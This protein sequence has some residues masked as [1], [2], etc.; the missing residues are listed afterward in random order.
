MESGTGFE[1]KVVGFTCNW[2]T[3]AG[4]DLAGTSRTKYPPNIRIVRVMCSGRIDPIFVIKALVNGADAVF[5]GGCHPGD[6]HYIQGNYFARRRINA[7]KKILEN[8]GL[9]R[10]LRMEWIS[11]SEGAKFAEVMKE[12]V[13]RAKTLGP[14][15]LREELL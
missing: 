14:N 8:F 12:L 5:I 2:C 1:P 10:R 9:D 7:L 11:A 13:E 15:P 3:Y 6:C 4:A